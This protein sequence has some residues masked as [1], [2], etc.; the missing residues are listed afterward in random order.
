MNVSKR[1]VRRILSILIALAMLL[2]LAACGSQNN[3]SPSGNNS[4][5]NVPSNADVPG[6]DDDPEKGGEA[7]AEKNGEV[8][9]LYTVA[10]T[11]YWLTGHGDGYTAFDGAELL[12]ECVKL[13]N[14]ALMYYIVDTLG[15]NTTQYEDPY[16]E[17]R[18]TIIDVNN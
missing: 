10:S 16:G 7:P 17:G 14:Q 8:Y 15:G 11:D 18:I 3:A 9:V 4:G 1:N 2:S 5:N 6:G 12:Q 13:D